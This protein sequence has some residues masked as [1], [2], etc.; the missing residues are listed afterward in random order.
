MDII[1]SPAGR[2][3]LKVISA[4]KIFMRICKKKKKKKAPSRVQNYFFL[5]PLKTFLFL[6]FS[7]LISYG[8]SSRFQDLLLLLLRMHSI[9]FTSRGFSHGHE[10]KGNEIAP[11]TLVH[12]QD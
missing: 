2:K 7:F 5:S 4:F 10:G 1:F 3:K 9:H 6:A 12:R 11:I 8:N